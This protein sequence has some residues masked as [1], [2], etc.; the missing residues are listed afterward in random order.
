M[1]YNP[2]LVL[3][4]VMLAFTPVVIDM[5][6]LHVAVPSLTLALGATGNEV[7]WI[8]DIY[9]LV[10]AGLLVP[11]GTLADRVGYRRMLLV[12][13]AI[14]TVA[15]TAAAFSPTA[16]ALIASR[17]ALGIG[18]AMIMPNVLALIRQ[19]FD[20]D[21]ERATALGIWS[22]VGM[23]G[24]AIGPLA[25]GVLLEHFWWGSVFLVNVPVM[26]AV[27]PMVWMLVPS[28]P[29]RADA[30]WKPGQAILLIAGLILAVYGVKTGFKAGLNAAFI[31]SFVPG[32]LL[33]AWF[34]RIQAK[35]AT[36]MLDLSL[37]R[38]PAIGVGLLMA[39]VVSGSL[40]GFELVLAQELQFV[41]GRSPLQAGI[42]MLPLV[43]AAAVGG[44][45]GGKLAAR[46]GLRAVASISMASAALSLT[47]LSF[48]DFGRDYVLVATFLATL[49]FSL[50]VG[51]LASSIAIM[52]S[53]PKE[54]AGAAGA[55]E[56]TGYELGGGLGVTGFGVL[57]NSVFRSAYSDHAPSGSGA[58]N[59]IGEAMAEAHRLGGDTGGRI[60]AL[61][62]DS[63][64]AAHDSVLLIV[65]ILT[66]A[67]TVAVFVALKSIS[68]SSTGVH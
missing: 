8:I 28:A 37:L 4:A 32:V 35:S 15:S 12:G 3:V 1:R 49:G 6:I 5:T 61:A 24:A 23:A 68:G 30:V 25:G 54:K 44:P 36:P 58:W 45:V 11:M 62:R 52:G 21:A 43:A 9:P 40:A 46:F 65:A 63:F 34:G 53:A 14:F 7:L 50:G 64:V 60:A 17:A 48:V 27:I 57:V 66:A 41:M 13:L 29:G 22:V 42:F 31:A 10:M 19:A 2:W 55:L 56:S 39:F 67:L 16:S 18:S 33:L 26:L 38:M 20:D 59:S 47:G 51:L